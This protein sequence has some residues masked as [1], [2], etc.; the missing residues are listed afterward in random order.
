MFDLLCIVC[1]YIC[2]PLVTDM[3]VYS[4]NQDF[5]M[6]V[7]TE[8]SLLS[9]LMYRFPFLGETISSFLVTYFMIQIWAYLV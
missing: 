2:A 1:V 9:C 3:C 8:P 5:E 7:D 4:G 6:N